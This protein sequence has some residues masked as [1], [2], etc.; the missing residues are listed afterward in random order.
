M[1]TFGRAQPSCSGGD[2]C[3][4]ATHPH[5]LGP[6]KEA[7]RQVTQSL[8]QNLI[9]LEDGAWSLPVVLV[10]KNDR[11]WRFGVDN[12]MLNKVT[13]HDAYP[14]PRIDDNLDSL[15]GSRF[16]ST[17]NLTSGYWQVL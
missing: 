7:E 14:I 3:H 2:S 6:D 9:E 8:E 13:R 5:Q 1:D 4:L 12:S 17:L 10:R 15:V 16:F 11:S